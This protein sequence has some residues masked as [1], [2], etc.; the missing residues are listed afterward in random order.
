MIRKHSND[1]EFWVEASID[2]DERVRAAWDL[3]VDVNK[4]LLGPLGWM[5]G[6]LMSWSTGMKFCV[7][8][9]E[10]GVAWW[11][12]YHGRKYWC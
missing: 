12:W 2:S 3:G 7:K 11:A 9:A 10:Y 4:R 8:R 5:G 6:F 1:L